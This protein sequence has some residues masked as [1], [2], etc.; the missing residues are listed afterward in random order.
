ME[1]SEL[2][3]YAEE[4][5]HIQE[6]HKWADFPGFSVLVDPN[7]EKWV[8]LLMRR[9]DS[10][11][12]TEIQRCDIKCGRQILSEINEPYL[13]MPFRMKGAKWVGVSFGDSTKSEVVCRLFDRA[14]YS[15]E[16]RGYTIE[17]N[18]P[19]TKPTVVYNDTALPLV[20]TQFTAPD[21]NIPEKIR[22]MQMLYEYKDGS[23]KQKCRNFYIQGKFMEDYVDNM[24]W[25]GELRHYFCTYH[26]LN[27]PQL[28]GYFTWR[29]RVRKGDF[30]PIAA[31]LAYIYVYELLNGIGTDSPEDAL[32]KMKEFEI[33]YIDPKIGDPHMRRNLYRWMLEYA[34]LNNVPPTLARQYADPDLME[35]DASLPI[36]KNPKDYSDEEIFSAICIFAAK[37]FK[38]SPVLKK[39]DKKG[40][41]LF[42]AVWRYASEK[43]SQNGK[44]L[45]TAC[46]GKQKVFPWYPLANSIYWAEYPHSDTDYVLNP[47]RS[48]HCR[49]GV[50][51]EKR[52]ANLY[53]DSDRFH[54][55][56]HETERVIRRCL[57]TGHYLRKNPEEAWVTPYV[58]QVL[59]EE[60]QAEIEAARPKITIDLS[61]LEQI[62]QD[63]L[64]TRDSLLTEEETDSAE[65]YR[66]KKQQPEE[67]TQTIN[68]NETESIAELDATHSRILLDLLRGEAVETY[69]KVN[70]LMPS[71]AADTI[72][73]AL[74]DEIGDNVL[75]CD[76]NTITVVEDYREDILQM[77]GGKI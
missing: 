55:F 34:V 76:G 61:N 50:W 72:N 19:P 36:L 30:S 9:W 27:I 14:V 46:F 57:K 37:R 75:E 25:N 35:T 51:T 6:Q 22:K 32:K 66:Q 23:F 5:F 17:L 1:L 67:P 10:D 77:V 38:Q 59:K 60:R 52:Y 28:R 42:A 73:D 26:D 20:G 33:G 4:K 40:K 71:V 43:Y 15:V 69:M 62:R 18:T 68:Q 65:D 29:T 7:T 16:Q 48:F 58:E 47:C 39:D 44:T 70:H 64:I 31:S 49:D 41:H 63:A 74:F 56:M 21:L 54:A 24:P 12:G 13:S 45:F 3:A 53:F 8:A 2:T 11:T